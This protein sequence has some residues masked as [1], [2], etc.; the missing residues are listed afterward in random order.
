MLLW[1]CLESVA[2]PYLPVSFGIRILA[3][4][5]AI[6]RCGVSLKSPHVCVCDKASNP[7][8]SILFPYYVELEELEDEELDDEE[9]ELV[10][11]GTAA[12]S[13][14]KTA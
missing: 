3:R 12:S 2:L 6:L 10:E 11:L 8:H 14:T 9:L 1:N 4:S 13:F 7:C 5:T